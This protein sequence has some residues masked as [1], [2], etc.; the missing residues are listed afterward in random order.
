ME[1]EKG[2]FYRGIVRLNA[3]DRNY[4]EEKQVELAKM[5]RKAGNFE[6]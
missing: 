3:D 4:Q 1:V 2:A 5:A 6:P